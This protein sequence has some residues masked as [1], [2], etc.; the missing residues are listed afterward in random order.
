MEGDA[1]ESS[2]G[3]GGMSMG[4]AETARALQEEAASEELQLLRKMQAWLAEPEHLEESIRSRSRAISE[5]EELPE[6]GT[7]EGQSELVREIAEV[8]R[9]CRRKKLYELVI[10]YAKKA[11]KKNAGG[12]EAF[13]RRQMVRIEHCEAWIEEEYRKER[14][15]QVYLS[16]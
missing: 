15:L 4:L 7:M 1:G 5:K 14:D 10:L 3:M 16:G 6:Y 12:H 2:E 13:V 11:R 8:M 9:L